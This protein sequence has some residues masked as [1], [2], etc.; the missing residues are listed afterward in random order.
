[1][2][3][4]GNGIMTVKQVKRQSREFKKYGISLMSTPVGML[5]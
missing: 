5:Q 4:Y 2:E 1:M 3:V